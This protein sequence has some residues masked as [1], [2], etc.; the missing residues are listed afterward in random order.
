MD[1]RFFIGRGSP[2]VR[3]LVKR[4]F[5]VKLAA[6]GASGFVPLRLFAQ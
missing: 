6:V 1:G 4:E 3:G 2:S 5:I